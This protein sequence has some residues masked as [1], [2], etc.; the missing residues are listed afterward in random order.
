MEP[1]FISIENAEIIEIDQNDRIDIKKSGR[2]VLSFGYTTY[3]L[4]LGYLAVKI[5]QEAFFCR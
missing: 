4:N 3:P 1:R 5:V 2:I